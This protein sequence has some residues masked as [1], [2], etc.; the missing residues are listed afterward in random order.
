MKEVTKTMR[1]IGLLAGGLILL[2]GG[3]GDKV[4]PGSA[5]AGRP[6]VTGVEVATVAASPRERVAEVVGTVKAAT[7]AAVASQVMGRIADVLVSEGSRVGKGALLATIEAEAIVAQLAAAEGAVA[8]AQ[9]GRED[10]ERAVSQAEAGK[11]L[12]EKTYGRYKTLLD[13]KVVTRQEFDEIEAKRTVAVKEY[14]RA[15]ER[16]A[17]LAARL[18][19]ARAGADAARATAAHAKVT[20]P[21]SGIV[22]EKKI[23]AGSMAVPGV[24]LFVLEGAGRYRIEAA[25]P[26]TYLGTVKA[27]TRVRV[28]L[29]SAP[30]KEISSVVSEVTPTVDPMSRTFIAKAELR[31]PGLRTG[32]FGRIRFGTGKAAV[33]AVPRGAISRVGGSDALFAVTADNV[34][35]LVMVTTGEPSGDSVEILSGI[36]PG[37]RIAVSRLDKLVDGVRVEVR[38]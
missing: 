11:S 34:A 23:E 22:T 18:V 27:G 16:R 8:E 38:K 14:E 20:A 10:A 31:A 37:A 12:A 5:P 6:V 13:E 32:M 15:L 33:L 2:A 1:G 26:E 4:K 9:A 30:G 21:F 29:D 17:Q 35:R 25:V 7:V 28:I 36:E 24:P 3:C 19:Q